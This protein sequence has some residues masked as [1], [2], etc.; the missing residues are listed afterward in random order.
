MGHSM[1]I[2]TERQTENCEVRT[3]P[4]HTEHT[5]KEPSQ[6]GG[7]TIDHKCINGKGTTMQQSGE[8]WIYSSDYNTG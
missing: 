8:K 4:W 5:T 3:G 6:S 7:E 1:Y 2:M